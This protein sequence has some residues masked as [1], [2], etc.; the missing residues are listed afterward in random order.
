V[1]GLKVTL[2]TTGLKEFDRLLAELPKATARNVLRRV[3]LTAAAPMVES[4]KRKAPRRTGK[5]AASIKATVL[6][7]SNSAGKLAY[8]AAKQGGASDADAG[9]ALRTANK[10]ASAGPLSVT[11]SVG[12]TGKRSAS[13]AHLEEFGTAHAKAHPHI[14]PAFDE[15]AEEVVAGIRD[16]LGA[17]IDKAKTRLA[18]KAAKAGQ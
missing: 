5:Y 1:T 13:I 8:R 3:G 18:K 7:G 12:P 14:R 9:A 11:I 15:T 10:A 2:K 16:G 6:T 4:Q 17:E